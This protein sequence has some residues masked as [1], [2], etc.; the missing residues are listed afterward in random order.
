MPLLEPLGT[1]IPDSRMPSLPV[2]EALEVLEELG[3]RCRPRLPRRVV[4][5]LEL[6][7]GKEASPRPR[8]P[9]NSPGGLC[10]RR[11]HAWRLD[12]RI[13][14]IIGTVRSK[15]WN[16]WILSRRTSRNTGGNQ[17]PGNSSRGL[18]TMRASRCPRAPPIVQARK[19][20]RKRIPS[21][22][23][24]SG[25]ALRV[26]CQQVAPLSPAFDHRQQKLRGTPR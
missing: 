11:S 15:P 3:A 17:W 9:S 14:P 1:E 24:G 25:R 7:R 21:R 4:D 23:L 20:R 5:E 6:Q 19:A 18:T 16:I 10:C 2:V 26:D 13:T 8:C 22:P 12:P